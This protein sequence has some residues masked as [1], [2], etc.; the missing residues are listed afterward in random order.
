MVG[1]RRSAPPPVVTRT[2]PDNHILFQG[3]V[4]DERREDAKPKRCVVVLNVNVC[5]ELHYVVC[6][7]CVICLSL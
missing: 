1:F 5:K 4:T 2:V 6:Y 3:W 7:G